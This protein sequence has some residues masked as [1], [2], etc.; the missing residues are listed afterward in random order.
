MVDQNVENTQHCS[1][2]TSLV[3]TFLSFFYGE[4][5]RSSFVNDFR[6][7]VTSRCFD[8]LDDA[9]IFERPNPLV[10]IVFQRNEQFYT[11]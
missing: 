2:G 7:N 4:T 6:T 11:K 3:F 10:T 9:R 5:A 1:H 8:S